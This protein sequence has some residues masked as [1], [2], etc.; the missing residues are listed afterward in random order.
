MF[1]DPIAGRG[2]QRD[3]CFCRL[4]LARSIQL[5]YRGALELRGANGQID[6]FSTEVKREAVLLPVVR[7]VVILGGL[8]S[9]APGVPAAPTWQQFLDE[10]DLPLLLAVVLSFNAAALADFV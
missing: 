4:T 5:E 9:A 10:I 6:Q 7:I 8:F 1:G 2:G 3:R